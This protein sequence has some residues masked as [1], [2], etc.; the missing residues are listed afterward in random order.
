M[1]SVEPPP[2]LLPSDGPAAG[3]PSSPTAPPPLVKRP[4]LWAAISLLLVFG[5]LAVLY[6]VDPAQGRFYPKCF[7]YQTTGLQCPGCGGLRAAHAL[8]HGEV[9]AAFRLNPMLVLLS[10]LLGYVVLRE[11]MRTVFGREW[12]TPFRRPWTLWVLLGVLLA[13]MLWRNLP[14]FSRLWGS[15]P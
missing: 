13:Y 14:W 12:P 2:L 15:S 6:W 1:S 8:L 3:S 5:G 9:G 4:T 7:L 11:I 10:P